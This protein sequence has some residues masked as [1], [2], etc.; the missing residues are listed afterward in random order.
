MKKIILNTK[1]KNIIKSL[2]LIIS[3]IITFVFGCFSGYLNSFT[4]ESIN[5]DFVN[6]DLTCSYKNTLTRKNVDITF[7]DSNY[8]NTFYFN[9]EFSGN[10]SLIPNG[11][12]LVTFGDNNTYLYFY[13]VNENEYNFAVRN[14][15]ISKIVAKYTYNSSIFSLITDSSDGYLYSLI[16]GDYSP[17]NVIN[18]VNGGTSN[19]FGAGILLNYQNYTSN[20]NGQV[21]IGVSNTYENGYQNGM[22]DGVKKGQLDVIN[23]L[24]SFNLYSESQF[25]NN[26]DKGYSDG[27]NSVTPDIAS[28]GFFL[29][30]G[31][32]LNAP[33]NILHGIFNFE[34]FGINLFSLI[35]FIFTL[36]LIAFVV[37]LFL[38]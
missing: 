26:Y 12:P 22:T 9:K 16:C 3:F 1:Q 5:H 14:D 35:S 28:N 33:Y 15:T 27:K 13:L 21:F 18:N 29:M 17:L 32:I 7:N 23:N 38:K 10:T 36:M 4:N 8:S 34:L 11:V 25:N 19:I 31:S 24:S 20:F 30:I 6:Y 37:K 2:I